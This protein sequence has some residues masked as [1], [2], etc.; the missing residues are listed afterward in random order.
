VLNGHIGRRVSLD[1]PQKATV[2]I[3][4]YHPARMDH[5]EAQVRNVLKCSFVDKLVISNHNPDVRIEDKIK[6]KDGRLNFI[7]QTTRR[8]CGYRWLVAQELNPEYLIVVDDDIWFFPLQLAKLFSHLVAEPL[9]P[10]GITGMLFV[11]NKDLEYHEKKDM[12][13]DFLCETYAVT[14]DQVNQYM[15]LRRL[16]AKNE[17]LADMIDSAADFMIISR[18]GAGKPKIHDVGRLFKADT[19]KQVDVAVHKN[20]R[21]DKSVLEVGR[22]LSNLETLSG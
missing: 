17:D 21:F 6:I 13:V 20:D 8:G 22:V 15:E 12:T 18:A 19:F 11:E 4:Y 10:H 16:V 2:L 7:N 9:I 14:G 1:I 3:T 5:I